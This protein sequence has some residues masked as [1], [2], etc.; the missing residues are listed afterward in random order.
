MRG[1]RGLGVVCLIFILWGCGG[2]QPE[3]VKSP[4]DEIVSMEEE[5]ELSYEV[6]VSIPGILV[7]Q[8][9]YIT[10]SAKMAVFSGEEMPETFQVMDAETGKAVFWGALENRG[11]D[12]STGKYSSYGDF[13]ELTQPGTYYIEA[14]MLGRS[15]SFLVEED[16]YDSVFEEACKQ[17]FYNRCGM[18]LTDEYAGEMAHNA[19]HTGKTILREDGTVSLDV[20]GGWHHDENGSK[21]V[22]GAAESIGVILLAYELY[23]NSFTD[24]MGIPESGNGIPDILDEVRY[25]VEWL[26]KMQDR[27]TGAVY[28]GVTF[29]DAGNGSTGYVEPFAMEAT[30]AFSMAVAKFSYL[31]QIYDTEYA[32]SCLQAADRAWKYAELNEGNT[33]DEW[34]FAAAAELYRA[35]G[36]QSC[37]RIVTDYLWKGTYRI[38]MGEPAFLGCVTY[39]STKQTVNLALC[40]EITG[41][42]MQKAEDVSNN[43]RSSV[44]LTSTGSRRNSNADLLDHMMYL[45]T[46]DHII[47]NHEYEKVIENHLHYFMGRNEDAISYIDHVGERN[48]KEIDESLGI[49]KRFHEDSKLIFMLSEIVGSHRK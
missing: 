34:R 8:L 10:D 16:L 5:P 27:E 45:T 12:E 4:E 17:Y 15:Y 25:E 32:V 20:T 31:Y 1:I 33:E 2:R 42:L 21:N 47:T 22:T 9:G 49:M 37:H 3:A 30:R 19:C 26:L 11:Y 18:T 46:I 48:Y 43:A 38:Y 35:S 36:Q 7:N 41:V 6:P 40:E 24:D 29:Y 28:A 14:P 44:Y 13:T 23:G 39:I